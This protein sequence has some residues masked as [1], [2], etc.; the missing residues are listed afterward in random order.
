MED[1][2]LEKLKSN[3]PTD[4]TRITAFLILFFIDSIGIFHYKKIR[5]RVYHISNICIAT[6]DTCIYH[7]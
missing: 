2:R 3:K 1:I 5:T 7:V 4:K 6:F